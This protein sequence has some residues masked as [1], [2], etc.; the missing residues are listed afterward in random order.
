MSKF[1]T[2]F[3]NF[4][5]NYEKVFEKNCFHVGFYHV[6]TLRAHLSQHLPC[7]ER[8]T[9]LI[10]SPIPA[11]VSIF[12]RNLSA[13]HTKI[14]LRAAIERLFAVFALFTNSAHTQNIARR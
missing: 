1:K 9:V 11:N 10:F 5:K 6:V 4:F 7:V 2:I 14:R 8:V 3:F 12:E 13:Q